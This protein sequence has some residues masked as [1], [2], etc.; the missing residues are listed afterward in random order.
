MTGADKLVIRTCINAIVAG[1]GVLRACYA[2][3]NL[4]CSCFTQHTHNLAR[5]GS[6]YNGVI[7]QYHALAVNYAAYGR[8]LHLDTL[9]TQ[10]LRGLDERT[11]HVFA[12]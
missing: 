11:S 8:Q 6:A 7:N 4:G 5:C 2:H 12:L 9:V 10:F 1:I 3:M